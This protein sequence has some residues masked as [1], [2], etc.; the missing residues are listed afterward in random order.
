MALASFIM[1]HMHL[2]SVGLHLM[3][4]TV[5]TGIQVRIKLHSTYLVLHKIHLV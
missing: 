2:L 3:L 1:Q 5:L 4:Y